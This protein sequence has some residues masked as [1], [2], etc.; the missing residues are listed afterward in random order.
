MTLGSP[1]THVQIHGDHSRQHCSQPP[2]S[3][4]IPRRQCQHE[5]ARF[6]WEWT[7]CQVTCTDMYCPTAPC[8][9]VAMWGNPVEA[10]YYLF[11]VR[12]LDL[13]GHIHNYKDG[14]DGP[15]NAGGVPSFTSFDPLDV[16][17]WVQPFTTLYADEIHYCGTDFAGT[18]NYKVH[19]TDIEQADL[20]GNFASHAFSDTHWKTL[21]DKTGFGKREDDA[22][23]PP[24]HFKLYTDRGNPDHTCGQ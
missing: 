19:F 12:R 6:F 23:Y 2:P 20:D 22:V 13:T 9:H 5:T 24:A 21:A 10:T 3:R 15:D 11:T 4:L 16:S 1:P 17:Q 8:I 14:V 7:K 18:P